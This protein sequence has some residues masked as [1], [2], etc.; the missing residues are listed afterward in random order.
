MVATES[1]RRTRK[2]R[3]DPRLRWAGWGSIVPFAAPLDSAA[4][5]ATAV[6]EFETAIRLSGSES[7]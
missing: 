7:P 6:E 1:E 4:L 3:I 2:K 5:Q